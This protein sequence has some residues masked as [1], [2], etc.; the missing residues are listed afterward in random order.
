MVL[1]ST[2]SADRIQATT[3]LSHEGAFSASFCLVVSVTHCPAEA[4]CSL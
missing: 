2:P 3:D 4:S 1:L